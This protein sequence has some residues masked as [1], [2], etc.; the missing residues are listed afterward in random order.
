MLG[1][2]SAYPREP[3]A[4]CDSKVTP[5]VALSLAYRKGHY[6]NLVMRLCRGKEA[7]SKK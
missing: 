4:V 5:K 1:F 3:R 7:R 2:S 6:K